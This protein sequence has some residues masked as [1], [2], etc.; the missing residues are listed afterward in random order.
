MAQKSV[1]GRAL[2]AS[3]A[4][5][6][7]VLLGLCLVQRA[8][9]APPSRPTA[10]APL[11]VQ[12]I[13]L[14]PVPPVAPP[15]PSVPSVTRGPKALSRRSAAPAGPSQPAPAAPIALADETPKATARVQLFPRA[16]D[17]LA[18]RGSLGTETVGEPSRGHTVVNDGFGPDPRARLEKQGEDAARQVQA[19]ALA[20]LGAAQVESGMVAPYFYGM[21]KELESLS[22]NV[23]P[24]IADDPNLSPA[25]KSLPGPVRDFVAAWSNGAQKYASSGSP[26]AA[27][28]VPEG[29]AAEDAVNPAMQ[30]ANTDP[31]SLAA[32]AVKPFA[33]K[34]CATARLREFADGRYG[35]RLVARVELRQAANGSLLG[36]ALVLPSGN[37]LFDRHVLRIAP[38][39]VAAAGE[40]DGCIPAGGRASLWEFSGRV[41]YLRRLRPGESQPKA[42]LSTV[43]QTVLLSLLSMGVGALGAPNIIPSGPFG[44]FD[45][46]T[47]ETLSVDFSQANYEMKVKLLGL[48]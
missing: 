46:T 6:G 31:N 17:L 27:D 15:A 43:A 39:A 42:K 3:L 47:G 24:W 40:P 30:V 9:E 16:L 10:G 8:P 2:L 20:D 37:P 5:H 7:L 34:A 4:V 18:A 12:V 13:T 14:P 44:Y 33:D 28:S 38:Q 1:L 22:K 32:A 41:T 11:Y 48:Y 26:Y 45:E 29:S 19:W 23:E 36:L 35:A 21:R 25:L